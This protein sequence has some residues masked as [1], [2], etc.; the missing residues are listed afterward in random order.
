MTREDVL[1]SQLKEERDILERLEALKNNEF[2][3]AYMRNV[4]DQLDRRREEYEQLQPTGLDSLVVNE[5]LRGSIA[6]LTIAVK[7]FEDW[8]ATAEDSVESIKE[9]LLEMEPEDE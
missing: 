1:L 8:H 3:Q 2:F 6:G 7:L 4:R 5:F 9:A